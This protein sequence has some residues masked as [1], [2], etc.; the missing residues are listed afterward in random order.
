[1]TFFPSRPLPGVLKNT[2]V[3]RQGCHG[4]VSVQ[5]DQAVADPFPRHP[6]DAVG[7]ALGVR[8]FLVLSDGTISDAPRAA[9][10]HL[11][12]QLPRVQVTVA[13]PV[14][15]SQHGQKTRRG[16]HALYAR[17]ADLRRDFVH[18]LRPTVRPHHATGALEA[19]RL[20]HG[21]GHGGPAGDPGA[22]AGRLNRAILERGWGRFVTL[23]E[24]KLAA[25]GG[26]LVLGPAADSSQ[27]CPQCGDDRPP[28]RQYLGVPRRWYPAPGGGLWRARALA[29][30]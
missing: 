26:Q 10:G 21:P 1:V 14:T 18:N 7:G 16:L 3:R 24:S 17:V 22:S 13:R 19:L 8:H 27:E 2:T 30:R 12:Q 11:R 25:Q 5:T 29:A 4:C 20:G 28:G 6:A 15:F 9:S 23:L